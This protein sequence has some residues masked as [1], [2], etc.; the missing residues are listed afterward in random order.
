MRFGAPHTEGARTCV[1]SPPN[2]LICTTILISQ[3]SGDEG[4][5][6]IRVAVPIEARNFDPL[7]MFSGVHN[8]LFAVNLHNPAF[9]TPFALTCSPAK[10][11]A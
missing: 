7:K 6:L 9:K 4:D 10:N 2:D 5:S 3:A 1:G 11:P 8:R